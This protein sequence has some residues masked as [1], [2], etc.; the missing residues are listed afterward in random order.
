MPRAPDRAQAAGHAEGL[1]VACRGRRRRRPVPYCAGGCGRPTGEGGPGRPEPAA[2]RR[3]PA[4]R[5]LLSWRLP[6]AVR[7]LLPAGG[8]HWPSGAAAMPARCHWPSGACHQ[9]AAAARPAAATGRRGLPPAG[10]AAAR[11][12]CC[13]RPS[14]VGHQ[15][16][17]APAAGGGLRGSRRRRGRSAGEPAVAR[18]RRGSSSAARPVSGRVVVPQLTYLRSPPI[19]PRARRPAG[20]ECG[21]RLAV[22]REWA[23]L[24]R[25]DAEPRRRVATPS[26]SGILTPRQ[27]APRRVIGAA[28][29]AR[30][31][32]GPRFVD[33]LAEACYP[34]LLSVKG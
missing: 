2:D 15:P 32:A 1:T 8:C 4:A 9:P 27:G 11:P 16:A 26:R 6:L 21:R 10:A 28:G 5:S 34:N 20:F 14:G 19:L 3:L 12:A 23:D 29:G 7:R 18:A 31:R 30:A 22:G 13:Q 33:P 24:N 25:A 17:V